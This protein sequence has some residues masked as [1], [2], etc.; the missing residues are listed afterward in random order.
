[1][2]NAEQ[3]RNKRHQ[4]AKI[5][6]M[7]GIVLL[8]GAAIVVLGNLLMPVVIA[9]FAAY[10]LDPIMNRFEAKGFNR[11]AAILVFL[12]LVAVFLTAAFFIIVPMIQ[13]Q[14]EDFFANQP[15]YA[16]RLREFILTQVVPYLEKLRGK[17]LPHNWEGLMNELP[18]LTGNMLAQMQGSLENA[19]GAMMLSGRWLMTVFITIVLVPVFTFYFLRDFDGLKIWV[20]DLFPKKTKSNWIAYFVEIDQTMS[21][22]IRGQVMICLILGSLYSVG[23]TLIGL[24]MGLLIGMITGGLAF[25][26]YVGFSIGMF[27]A[28]AMSIFAWN[29]PGLLVATLAVFGV[30]QVA[31][32]LFITPR[33]L[34]QR[35]RV[36]PMVV[37]IALFVGGRLFGFVGMLLAVPVTAIMKVTFSHLIAAYRKS[38][39]YLGEETQD[40]P[41]KEEGKD[42]AKDK[43]ENE[44]QADA[45]KPQA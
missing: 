45:V 35:L 6:W 17:K 36:S 28:V 9:F 16:E 25:I 14:A 18:N 3:T 39:F 10:L 4:W 44:T 41:C 24:P 40:C 43:I 37:I 12:A 32:G 1:M 33:I 30:V 5:G 34:G 21:S 20:A 26:P 38:P 22:I 2:D 42:E 15:K 23:L 11:A 13:A 31:D 7:L 29:G 8:L 19:L 27:A